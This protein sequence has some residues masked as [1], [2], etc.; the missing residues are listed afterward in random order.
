MVD[1]A[2][3]QMTISVE[4]QEGL[5]GQGALERQAAQVILAPLRVLVHQHLRP[6][7]LDSDYLLDLGD[8][9]APLDLGDLVAPLDLGGHPVAAAQARNRKMLNKDFHFQLSTIERK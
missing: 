1:Q 3:R 5:D 8:L 2:G 4:G 7:R 9:V 6:R